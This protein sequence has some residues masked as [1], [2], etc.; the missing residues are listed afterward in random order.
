LP[1]QVILIVNFQSWLR[2][3]GRWWLGNG[4][5]W[6]RLFIFRGDWPKVVLS[7][8]ELIPFIL[9]LLID[10]ASIQENALGWAFQA[11]VA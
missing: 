4:W 1:V 10:F 11:L 2:I 6:L 8:R 9:I 5:R 3:R 7:G